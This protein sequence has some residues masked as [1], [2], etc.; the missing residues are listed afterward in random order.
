MARQLKHF[1]YCFHCTATAENSNQNMLV[2]QLQGL[3]NSVPNKIQGFLNESKWWKVVFLCFHLFSNL[4]WNSSLS[5]LLSLS[6]KF[7]FGFITVSQMFPLLVWGKR[8]WNSASTDPSL[9]DH[10]GD[11]PH[12]ISHLDTWDES[13]QSVKCMGFTSLLACPNWNAR[14]YL[15]K[16]QKG[17]T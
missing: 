10:G 8:Q 11:I 3:S 13:E 17:K 9:R 7:C 6:N 2:F 15:C 1:C 12:I 5:L 4:A 14:T 16:T